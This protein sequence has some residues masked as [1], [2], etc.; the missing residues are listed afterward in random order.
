[1]DTF[2]IRSQFGEVNG[3]TLKMVPIRD[4]AD[5]DEY[6]IHQ[7]GFNVPE[8]EAVLDLARKHGGRPDGDILR[9]GNTTQ[10]AVRDPDGNSIELYSSD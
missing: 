6:P 7:L 2:G 5:F 1:V 10:A 3:I 4:S 9:D 8:I